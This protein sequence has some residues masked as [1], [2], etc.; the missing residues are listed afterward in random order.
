MPKHSDRP[1]ILLT[2]DDGIRAPGLKALTS[3]LRLVADVVVVAPMDERS[4]ASHALTIHHPIRI[5]AAGRSRF[6]IT[7]TPVDCVL[8][9]LKKIASRR[10]DLV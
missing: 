1:L 5:E 10:P 7:G 3:A 6:A 2:N 9:G 8:F 4:A